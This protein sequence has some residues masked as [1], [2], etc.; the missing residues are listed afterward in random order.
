MPSDLTAGDSPSNWAI[1]SHSLTSPRTAL[2]CGWLTQVTNQ[3]VT[4]GKGWRKEGSRTYR[5]QW[6]VN[7]F[8]CNFLPKFHYRD[9]VLPLGSKVPQGAAVCD[10]PV[11]RARAWS[12]PRWCLQGWPSLPQGRY[13][14]SGV[15]SAQQGTFSHPPWPA[16]WPGQWKK[17]KEK[18]L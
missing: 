8:W 1:F 13:G 12:R 10:K 3:R 18:W 17:K 4:L 9:E 6:G 16:R 7:G 14:C 11:C 15:G 2:N 5:E